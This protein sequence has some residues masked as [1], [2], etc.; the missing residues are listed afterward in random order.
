[1][2]IHKRIQHLET[3][4]KQDFFAQRET[5][6]SI[7]NARR[8]QNAVIEMHDHEFSELVYV[9]AGSITHLYEGGTERLHAGDFFVIHPGKR[10]GYA[11]PTKNISYYNVLFDRHVT[12]PPPQLAA[13]GLIQAIYGRNAQPPSVIARAKGKTARRIGETLR[14]MKRENDDREPMSDTVVSGLFVSLLALLSRAIPGAPDADRRPDPVQV[15]ADF[16]KANF[17][18]HIQIADVAKTAGVSECALRRTF[19]DRIGVTPGDYLT[20]LKTDCAVR[21]LQTTD[22]RLS[23]IATRAGFHDA[24]HLFRTLRLKRGATPADFRKPAVDHGWTAGK[25]CNRRQ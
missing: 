16:L 3:L 7:L 2:N 8:Y 17:S 1:M 5:P 12:L 21:L 25:V 11:D 10:H 20:D 24:S 14:E 22:L 4:H 15:A 13:G 9:D 6:I 18:R 19:V 23:E